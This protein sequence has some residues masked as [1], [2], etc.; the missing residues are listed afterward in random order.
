MHTIP[1]LPRDA[2]ATTEEKAKKRSAQ[3]ESYDQTV[4]VTNVGKANTVTCRCRHMRPLGPL[5]VH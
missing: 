5:L 3:V 1:V 4:R 2:F